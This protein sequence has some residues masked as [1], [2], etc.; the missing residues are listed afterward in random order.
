MPRMPARLVAVIA[1]AALAAC[2]GDVAGPVPSPDTG[3]STTG[4]RLT[5]SSDRA[6]WYV[7]ARA[8]GTT[9]WGSDL[10]GSSNILQIDESVTL[11]LAPG[12]WDV[13]A[14]TTTS[15]GREAVYPNRQVIDGALLPL[16][17]AV[18]DWLAV[19]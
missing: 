10:L 2:G 14:R 13:R 17:I 8:C 16:T 12:C 5:N 11:A 15:T 4:I 9:A 18:G 3:T 1:L 6:A 19:D 7:Y